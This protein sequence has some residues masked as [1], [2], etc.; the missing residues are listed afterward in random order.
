MKLSTTSILASLALATTVT[1]STS[2]EQIADQ[3]PSCARSCLAE[4]ASS[5]GC[6]ETDFSCQC[7][8][9]PDLDGA[10]SDCFSEGCDSSEIGMVTIIAASI[11]EAVRRADVATRTAPLQP[12]GATTTPPSGNDKHETETTQAAEG[13]SSDEGGASVARVAVGW[14]GAA[15]LVAMM[16]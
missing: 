14:V 7:T 8:K 1:A 2:A 5:A 16:L 12:A 11:C 6:D 10:A 3:L 13:E 4:V 9:V 15:A